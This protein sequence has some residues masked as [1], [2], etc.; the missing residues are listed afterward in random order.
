MFENNAGKNPL[1][2]LKF[3]ADQGFTAVE[4]N[5]MMDRTP[6]LQEKMGAEMARLGLK[7]GVF[8]FETGN[9][10]KTSF[11]TGKKEFVDN[12]VDTAR[13]ALETSKRCGG[14]LTTVVPGFYERNLPIG[15]QTG[16]VID[17]L[18][19]GADLL[20]PEGLVMVL[21]PL[22]DTPDLFM[23]TSDQTYAL[24]RAVNSPVCKILFDIYHMQRNEGH[25]IP[26]IDMA[27]NEIAYFQIGDNPGRNEPTTGEINYKNIFKHIYDKAK[28]SNRSF[29]YGMEH[30]NSLPGKDGEMALIRA[31]VESD[32]FQS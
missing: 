1:D 16:N 23:R 7:M 21:E 30:G 5:G 15:I 17:V 22:S 12:F 11:T 19:R 9:N 10:W 3:M 31:Y 13:K 8:V 6:A 32:S 20:A 28:A 14:K 4:D 26:H 27:W 29:I 24:C 2:Q 18:R 25:I